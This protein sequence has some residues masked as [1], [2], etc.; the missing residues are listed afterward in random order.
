VASSGARGPGPTTP[1]RLGRPLVT[2]EAAPGPRRTPGHCLRA[3]ISKYPGTTGY[4]ENKALPFPRHGNAPQHGEA[5]HQPRL[6]TQVGGFGGPVL[7]PRRP[8]IG[9]GG[10]NKFNPPSAPGYNIIVPG[11]YN[12]MHPPGSH[13]APRKRV[14]LKHVPVAWEN[15]NT[16]PNAK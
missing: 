9:H 5:A 12:Q 6:A 2:S 8:R 14:A 16:R 10:Q 11:Y 3:P 13:Q 7:P 15:P 1:R 4:N